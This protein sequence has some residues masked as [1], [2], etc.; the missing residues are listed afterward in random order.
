M[1]INGKLRFAAWAIALLLF[2]GTSAGFIYWRR[3]VL[4]EQRMDENRESA[5]DIIVRT[6]AVFE[7]GEIARHKELMDRLELM[8]PTGH[9]PKDMWDLD[10]AYLREQIQAPMEK[11]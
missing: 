6:I 1:Q 7:Q 10:T 11:Q 5:I 3:S 4:A 2:V 9:K 8:H